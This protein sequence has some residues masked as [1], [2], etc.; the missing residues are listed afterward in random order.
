MS[1][2]LQLCKD[3]NSFVTLS[4]TLHLLH[5]TC[6]PS[7]KALCCTKHQHYPQPHHHLVLRLSPPCNCPLSTGQLIA[8]LTFHCCC[9]CA[10]QATSYDGT[11]PS[12]QDFPYVACTADSAH[13][14]G[15]GLPASSAPSSRGQ[16]S[17]TAEAF[18]PQ[19]L[20]EPLAKREPKASWTPQLSWQ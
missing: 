10:A 4:C 15:T 14:G 1:T 5:H 17:A 20:A 12:Q 2:G 6:L 13:S 19:Q 3:R 16:A 7:R 9:R 18:R 8:M 11:L